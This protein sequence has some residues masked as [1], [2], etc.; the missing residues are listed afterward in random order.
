MA[1]DR[2]A[3]G[4][5]GID[6][7][8]F[9]IRASKP[10]DVFGKEAQT[11]RAHLVRTAIDREIDFFAS[12]PGFGEGERILAAGL[13]GYRLR[14][15]VMSTIRNPELAAAYKEID[16]SLHLF[17]QHIDLLLA[18]WAA[19]SEELLTSF[20]RMRAMG[21][22]EAFGVA[23]QTIDELREASNRIVVDGLDLISIPATLLLSATAN[24]LVSSV[25]R[26][27]CGLIAY[28]PDG[29]EAVRGAALDN[30]K[31]NPKR[32]GLESVADVLAKLALSDNRITSVAIPVRRVRDLDRLEAIAS[33]RSFN[34]T[35]MEALRTG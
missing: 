20:A 32:H 13:I 26:R 31:V 2:R 17:D 33:A 15:T 9:G 21:D 4:Q 10:F 8:S 34:A 23:C 12:S 30:M 14:A 6:L 11:S 18:D 35:E 22:V 1:I 29:L 7:P 3:L 27:E 16:V 28:I 24:R 19:A 25:V 5:T